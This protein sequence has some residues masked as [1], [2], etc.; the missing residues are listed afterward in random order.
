M[1]RPHWKASE[2]FFI[3]EMKMNKRD[4][5]FL[6]KLETLRAIDERISLLD[7]MASEFDYLAEEIDPLT[8][9]LLDLSEGIELEVLN[10]LNELI[11]EGKANANEASPSV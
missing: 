4:Y 5:N 9:E 3:G 6:K 8:K 2:D 7:H 10:F 11:N 1:N